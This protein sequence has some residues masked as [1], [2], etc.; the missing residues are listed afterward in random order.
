VV[1]ERP[2]EPG[3]ARE[4]VYR[5]LERVLRDGRLAPGSRLPAARRLAQSWG[6]PRGAIDQACDR[7]RAEGVL[8]R[9]VGDG[10]YVAD[11]LPLGMASGPEPVVA[12]VPKR[13]AQKVL[14]RMS[15][16]LQGA[17]PSQHWAEGR[18]PRALRAGVPRHRPLSAGD[19]AP[20]HRARLCRRAAQQPELRSAAGHAEL[21]QATARYLTLTRGMRCSAEQVII[22]NSTLQATELIA[23]VL[24]S[25]GD[26]VCIEDPSHP[27]SARLLSLA[28]LDV[29]GVPFDEQGLDVRQ[30]REHSPRPAAIYLQPLH[31]YPTGIVTSEARRRE[32]LDWAD[33]SRAWIIEVDFLNEIAHGGAVQAPLQCGPLSE[34]VL[35]VGTYTGVMFP[36]IRLAYLVV[37]PGLVDAFSSVRGMLGDH[38]PVA[39]QQALAEFIDAGHL[40]DHLRAM[41]ST[42]RARRD[43]LQRALRGRL[44]AAFRLGP[45]VGG[46]S[47]CLHLPAPW[48]DVA[49]VESLGAR[50][51]EA[52]A[53]S[54][55][56]WSVPGLNGLVLGYGAYES[57]DIEAAVDE[58]VALLAGVRVGEPQPA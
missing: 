57:T 24:L 34:Q 38:S 1:D 6:L 33:A 41:R 11:R 49:V 48:S 52:G 31:Q 25:P 39:P 43:V 35:F 14:Q 8:V 2:P 27:S 10:S 21:R 32:L 17:R 42:Y 16:R 45:M 36:A 37:P 40:G 28:H 18:A 15:S 47:A 26:R 46:V 19:L 51:V 20:L 13:A 9:R 3:A 5:A 29:V 30:A 4:W 12:P 44:P 23:Q 7:L 50:G 58:L 54:L 56:G 55:H 22:V 53:L